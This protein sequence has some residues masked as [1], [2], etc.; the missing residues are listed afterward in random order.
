MGNCFGSQFLVSRARLT[1]SGPLASRQRHA[2]WMS[3]LDAQDAEYRH[4]RS[5]VPERPT[6]KAD[7]EASEMSSV[8]M[9]LAADDLG[10]LQHDLVAPFFDQFRLLAPSVGSS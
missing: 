3:S 7:V 5:P 8:L 10:H 9:Q 4:S 2:V 1:S 6:A